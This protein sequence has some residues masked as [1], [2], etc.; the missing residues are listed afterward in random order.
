M[1]LG[2]TFCLNHQVNPVVYVSLEKSYFFNSLIISVMLA[3]KNR[4]WLMLQVGGDEP[5]KI[6][7]CVF[8]VTKKLQ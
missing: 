2:V 7:N 1:P 5:T 4:A 6:T 3:P 8:V